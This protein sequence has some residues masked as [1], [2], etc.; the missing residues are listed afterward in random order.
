M[1]AAIERWFSPAWRTAHPDLEQALRTRMLANRP[2]EYAKAYR[3]FATG[4]RDLVDAVAGIACPL[5]AATGAE[6]R[7]STPAM[8]AAIAARVPGAQLRI[9]PGLRHMG[10]WEA[11]AVFADLIAEFCDPR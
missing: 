10:L 8:S 6:D 7:N 1:D 4:D 5:L 9:V 3:V 2:A 11:P